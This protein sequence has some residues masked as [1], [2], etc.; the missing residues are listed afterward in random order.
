MFTDVRSQKVVLIAH[1]LLNQ[2]SISDGT[3]VYPA[4]FKDMIQMFLDADVGIVQMP[5]PELCCLG[6]DRGNIRGADSPVVV[7]NTRIR[8]E[9]QKTDTY[10]KLTSLADYVMLQLLEYR[11]YGFQILGIIGAN[12]SPNCG[13]ETTSDCD[14]ETDGMGLFMEILNRRLAAENLSIPMLGIK[15]S[16][17]V[18]EKVRLLL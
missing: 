10:E 18:T 11:K 2:N 9:M 12:R 4:A 7:E 17:N 13:V 16:D 5:C 8:R 6:L 1:C 14:Q 3:A 15:G